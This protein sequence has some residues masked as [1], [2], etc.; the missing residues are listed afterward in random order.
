MVDL[1]IEASPAIVTHRFDKMIV[2]THDYLITSLAYQGQIRI[3]TAQTT[4]LTQEAC[5]RHQTLPTASAALGR[6]LTGGL[7]FASQLKGAETY[8]IRIAGNGP[9][10]EIVVDANA[11]GQVR[12]YV[13]NGQIDVPSNARGKLDVARLVGTSGMV[14]VVK[15][16]GYDH[17]F[18][19]Q[20]PIVSGE[21][22]EDLASYLVNSEQIPSAL[23]LG[24]L[25]NPNGTIATSGGYLVQAMPGCRD[26]ILTMM[27]K[28]VKDLPPIS[29]L[30]QQ[31]H[32]PES[33]I[34]LLVASDNYSILD[35]KKINFQC[36][37]SREK[38][39]ATLML[40]GIDELKDMIQTQHGADVH[41]NF[42]QEHYHF[43]EDALHTLIE[44]LINQ[45][46]TG[47]DS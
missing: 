16:F 11:Y 15:S 47:R 14:S 22:A 41:C 1:F 25:V 34:N 20:T 33:M 40:L 35:N 46:S 6:T 7:L 29:T 27:E 38:T 42:C 9:L 23:A 12:G 4:Q 3:V 5:R 2:M 45:A 28:Q 13:H 37:C 30:L 36:R 19:G 32:T 44:K 24:V 17:H 39:E 43:N 10:G 26:E 8:T 31:G 21:I 18:T